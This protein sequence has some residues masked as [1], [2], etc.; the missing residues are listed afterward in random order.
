MKR[1][2]TLWKLNGV[3]YEHT[4]NRISNKPSG[5]HVGN[6][7]S[8]KGMERREIVQVTCTILIVQVKNN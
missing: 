6:L 5:F 1:M 3:Q 7:A 2:I 4:T 8:E